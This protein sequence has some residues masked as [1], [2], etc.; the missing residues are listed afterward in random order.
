V[1]PVAYW[2]EALVVHRVLAVLYMVLP[3][4]AASALVWLTTRIWRVPSRLRVVLTVG[5]GLVALRFAWSAYEV[6]NSERIGTIEQIS[7]S[8]AAFA[9]DCAFAIIVL[10]IGIV[11][12]WLL[13]LRQANQPLQPTSGS[14][15]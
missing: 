4:L 11:S 3:V 9:I 8:L 1:A 7:A 10:M 2:T 12:E 15:F 14:E 13:R 6:A 5:V